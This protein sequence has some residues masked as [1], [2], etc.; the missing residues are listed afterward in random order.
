M[1]SLHQNTP[2]FELT[3]PIASKMSHRTHPLYTSLGRVSELL[4]YPYNGKI[5]MVTGPM[6]SS[7][8]FTTGTQLLTPSGVVKV[9]DVT[10]GTVL[11]TGS[12]P[13]PVISMYTGDED[14]VTITELDNTS[15]TVSLNHQVVVDANNKLKLVR[16]GDLCSWGSRPPVVSGCTLVK[17]GTGVRAGFTAELSGKDRVYGLTMGP[18]YQYLV[19]A[20][21]TLTHN[22]SALTDELER[23]R[24]AKKN[25]LL[26][27]PDIDRRYDDK[28]VA[29]G[30][31]LHSGKEYAKCPI[32]RCKRLG[33]LDLEMLMRY[34]V[35]GIDEIG[36]FDDILETVEWAN[37]G[38]RV[39]CCGIIGDYALH[40]FRN[41]HQLLPHCERIRHQN[42]VCN[43]CGKSAPFTRRISAETETLVVGG[44]DKYTALCRYCYWTWP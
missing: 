24:I 34:D 7:K 41:V 44:D 4:Q 17:Y 12:G 40:N 35:I 14:L 22:S 3:D 36:M 25:V 33:D 27:R 1:G 13:A 10:V 39:V 31:V 16:A 43:K 20:N 11:T 15:H 42:A 6:F 26:I 9:E 38:K 19:L 32:V 21:G 29:G 18:S 8:C 37:L 2:Q 23:Q 5:I 28:A 30:I